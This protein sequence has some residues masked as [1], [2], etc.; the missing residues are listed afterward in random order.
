MKKNDI[1][2]VRIDLNTLTA[3]KRACE[4]SSCSL[5]DIVRESIARELARRD[6]RADTGLV[7]L[8]EYQG[9]T[10]RGGDERNACVRLLSAILVGQ[11]RPRGDAERLRCKRRDVSKLLGAL[12]R[13]L[14]V[15]CDY[16]YRTEDRCT[17]HGADFGNT[18]SM[19]D[20]DLRVGMGCEDDIVD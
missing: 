18:L 9:S 11:A 17:I 20:S 4:D 1:L 13:V 10:A 12:F 2:R 6:G 14:D 15:P 3:L 16:A 7:P 19:G 8:D 5:S